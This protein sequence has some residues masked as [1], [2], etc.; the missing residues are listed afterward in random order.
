LLRILFGVIGFLFPIRLGGANG[1]I[2]G[3]KRRLELETLINRIVFEADKFV[4]GDLF[5]RASVLS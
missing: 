2:L 1:T 3:V 4:L 5:G